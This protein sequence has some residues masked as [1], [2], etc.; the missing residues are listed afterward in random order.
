MKHIIN[1]DFLIENKNKYKNPNP[2]TL[3]HPC[4]GVFCGPSGS[5]KSNA[6][7]NLLLTPECKMH[8]DRVYLFAKMVDEP[9]YDA[10]VKKFRITE[11]KLSKKNNQ[12]I[13]IL[14]TCNKLEDVPALE[15]LNK[16]CQNICIFDDFV[17][18]ENKSTVLPYWTMGRK[19]NCST[20][21][22]TQDFT[23]TNLTVRRNSNYLLLWKVNNYSDLRRIF[24]DA[25]HGISWV[26]FKEKYEKLMTNNIH[27]F[28]TINNLSADPNR[29]V[30]EG[31]TGED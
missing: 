9:L 27:G 28:L 10:I 29:R 7:A 17:T 22:L 1:Y 25:V 30:Y 15:S 2:L 21:F 24:N 20:F 31:L 23:M 18:E 16:E 19:Y 14:Y 13:Q 4:R 26:E 12:P 6:V 8:Y 11:E 5:G 3:Q